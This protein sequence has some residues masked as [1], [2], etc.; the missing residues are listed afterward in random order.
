MTANDS[1]PKFEANED[2]TPGFDLSPAKRLGSDQLFRDVGRLIDTAKQRA[3]VAVNA[4]LT[5]LYWRVGTRIQ[6]EVLQG[7]RAEYG[8]QIVLSLA[9][10]LTQVYGK[11]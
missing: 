7:Q 1:D 11:G 4:E 10:R 3:A 5:L 9:E 2:L 8:K 6:T